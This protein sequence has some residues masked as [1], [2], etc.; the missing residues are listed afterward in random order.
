MCV[1][2]CVCLHVCATVPPVT[3]FLLQLRLQDYSWLPRQDRQSESSWR[4]PRAEFGWGY[5]IGEDT[6]TKVKNV[7]RD[8][9]W[10]YF[11]CP[12]GN[13]AKLGAIREPEFHSVWHFDREFFSLKTCSQSSVGNVLPWNNTSFKR[14][15]NLGSF[16]SHKQGFTCKCHLCSQQICRS[17]FNLSRMLRK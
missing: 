16:Q 10:L 2:A 3:S 9:S 15:S 14:I 7:L 17:S 4:S 12:S 5:W 8:L 13:A 1:P 6:D 11:S